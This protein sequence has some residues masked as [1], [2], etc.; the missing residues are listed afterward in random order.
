MTLSDQDRGSFNLETI[1]E[2]TREEVVIKASKVDFREAFRAAFHL[3]VVLVFKA[4]FRA[5][6]NRIIDSIFNCD[7]M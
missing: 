5:P 6:Q 3:V 7:N 1:L 2:L 4:R